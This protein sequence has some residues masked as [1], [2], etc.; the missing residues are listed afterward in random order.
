M[1]FAFFVVVLASKF[2]LTKNND[3]LRVYQ[4][5]KAVF[6]LGL[7]LKFVKND[8]L[9]S[10]I[11][12]VVSL[13]VYKKAVER[14]LL[15]RRLREIVRAL[16]PNLCSGFDLVF[17]TQQQALQ[18]DFSQLKEQVEALLKKAKLLQKAIK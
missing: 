11:G 14:N 18:L 6:A 8:L 16:F 12:F 4:Q 10:R 3:F 2:R 13:K 15:K 5:G 1:N 9:R 7:V 17:L